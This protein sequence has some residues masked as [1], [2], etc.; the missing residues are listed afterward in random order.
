MA[1]KSILLTTHS[2]V[3]FAGAELNILS[4]AKQLIDLNY[5]VEIAT[6]QYSY[7]IKKDF[8]E[9]NLN[10]KNVLIENLELNHY[11]LIWS[12]H[13]PVLEK[14]LFEKKITADKIVYS[15]LSPFEPMEAP[16]IFIDKLTLCLANSEETKE[17][18]IKD[19]VDDSNVM[20]FPNFAS[21]E[22]YE[23]RVIRSSSCKK[24]CVVSNHIPDEVLTSVEKLLDLGFAVDI[25]GLGHKQVKVTPTVLSNYDAVITIGKTVQYSMIMGIPVFC[26]DIHGG[27]GWLNEENYNLAKYYNFSGRGFNNKFTSDEIVHKMLANYQNLLLDVD[28]IKHKA[29]EEFD[30][31]KNLN[32]ILEMLANYPKINL[33]KFTSYDGLLT[34]H[35]QKFIREY[36]YNN[37]RKV[38]VSELEKSLVKVNHELKQIKLSY[39]EKER[40]CNEKL[41][42]LNDLQDKYE[43][44]SQKY[45]QR[46]KEMELKITEKEENCR[47]LLELAEEKNETIIRMSNTKIW[48]LAEKIRIN[49]NRMLKVLKDPKIIVRKMR[50][51]GNDFGRQVKLTS[52]TKDH[53]NDPQLV[54]IVIP[55]YDRTEVLIESIESILNQTHKNIE[56]ILVCDGS[57]KDTIEIVKSYEKDSR[58]KAF[59]FKNNSGNAVRGRNKAIKEANGHYLAFQ[60]SD[61]IAEPDRIEK[62]LKYMLEYKAD[63]VYGG[64]K[65]IVDGTRDVGLA[66]NQEVY[67]PDCDYEFLKQICVPCQSTVMVRL[68]A[69]RKVGGLKPI[70][71]YR[72]DHELWLRLA[73]NGYKFKAIPEI[74]TGLRLHANN[75]ELAFKEDDKYWEE[76]TLSEHKIIRPMKPKIAYVV[77]GCGISGGLAVICQ[78]ANGL[79]NRGYDVLIITEDACE[80]IDWYPNQLVPVVSINNVPTNLDI[81]V[82]TYWTTAYTIDKIPAKEKFYFIQSDES[83]FFEEGSKESIAA[84]ETYEK[85][86]QHITMAKWLETWSMDK[87]GKK[88]RYVPNGVDMSIM[89]QTEPLEAKG[90]KLRIL[91]EG[92]INSPFKKMKDAFKVIEDLD[93]EVWCVSSGGSPEPTWKCDRFFEKVSMDKM[94]SIYSSCDVLLKMSSVESFCL[95]ALEMMA[96]GGVCVLNDF[97]G[98]SEFVIN[99]YNAIV[100]ENGS[101]EQA[102]EAILKLMN[103]KELLKKLRANGLKT[104]EEW[105]WNRSID[106]LEEIYYQKTLINKNVKMEVMV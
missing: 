4:I 74:L 25:Y 6:F 9:S 51:K 84:L 70:M 77:A 17:Q 33:K 63:V 52:I 57:P 82:A 16:P 92:P 34:K 47:Y 61:D 24:I 76:L 7:P 42:Q 81:V 44:L 72:E 14:L 85:D 49:R 54:S 62:S 50:K 1:I 79:L 35:N 29:R 27:P 102:K 26:Y 86:Y 32:N 98:V 45:E 13:A 90:E 56:L 15:S 104:A 39:S 91:L 12:Q 64:W 23:H 28:I 68:E 69:V 103:D 11:D 41:T 8:E 71:K 53:L 97:K 60:D 40:E 10:V 65:A 67:S 88:A 96:C 30:L 100:I 3:D 89:Y 5:Q 105:N 58:V 21:K 93:C 95:P 75:L 38:Q 66:N 106:I 78:H 99:D 87:F 20:V 73:Y 37:Y 36:E 43:L 55:V 83:L 31:L 94:K 80:S 22:F 59:Y 48:R 18:L 101:I 19:G 2:L 46:I